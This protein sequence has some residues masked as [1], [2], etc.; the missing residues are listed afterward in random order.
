MNPIQERR[1]GKV[2]TPQHVV[3]L[4]V[5]KLFKLRDPKPSDLVLDP[6]CG[7]GAFV[8]GILRWCK[9]KRVVPPEILGLEKDSRLLA[10]TKE[11]LGDK[12]KVKLLEQDFLLEESIPRADFVIGNPPYVRL[13]RLSVSERKIYRSRFKTAFNRFD[14]YILFFEKALKSLTSSGRLVFITPEKFE[15]TLSSGPL[16]RFMA[17]NYHVEE[18]HHIEEDAFKSLVTYPT[19]TTINRGIK[20]LTR[21]VLRDSSSFITRLPSDGSPWTPQIRGK[22]EVLEFDATLEDVCERIS[23]GVA[24]GKDEVFVVPQ[25]QVTDELRLFAYPTVRG[26]QLTFRGIKSEDVILVPYDEKGCLLPES[27]LGIFLN[28]LIRY[29]DV[30]ASRYC[31]RRGKREW[32]AFHENPPMKDMLKP[33]I[34]C[35]DIAKEPRFLLDEKGE[36]IPRHS[37]YYAIPKNAEML[38]VLLNFLNSSQVK[39]WL[40]A[41]CQRAANG[42]LRLQSSVLKRIPIPKHITEK[43][44]ETQQRLE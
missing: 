5:E 36:L 25:S 35:K 8:E 10:E 30:L 27:Q 9:R 33:K 38:P 19:I 7:Y 37:V 11:S 21:V 2:Y 40:E 44:T 32:Y 29:K 15:Y 16:R 4:M 42:F 34:L 31:V 20:G 24:T 12:G 22:N 41:N 13:E 3:D 39:E 1:Q 18:I 17:T 23:C 26:E 28:Y 14:L 43:V 6:G